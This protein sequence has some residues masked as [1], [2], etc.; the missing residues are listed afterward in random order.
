MI[1]SLLNNTNILFSI[2][3]KKNCFNK[4]KSI[5]RRHTR[6][7]VVQFLYAWQ[8]SHNKITEVDIEF[9]I[10]LN[11]QN[12][13]I[14]YFRKLYFGSIMYIEILDKLIFPY[15]TRSLYEVGYVER[16]ILCLALF[17]FVYQKN[18]PYKVIINEA[19]EL[20]KIFGSQKSYKFTNKIL[21]KIG[22]NIRPNKK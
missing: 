20:S 13:D 6:M 3:L 14:V 16:S 21:D 11:K 1:I 19:I 9:L 12:V 22:I 17:E 7:H 4:E 15:T 2:M 8:I 5:I 18:V 10:S